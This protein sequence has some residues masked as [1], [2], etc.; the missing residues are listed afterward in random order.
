MFTL[1]S[2]EIV[3]V[4]T[5]EIPGYRIEHFLAWADV[6][7]SLRK[8]LS[9]EERNV[10]FDTEKVFERGGILWIGRLHGELAT[11][12]WTRGGSNVRSWFLPLAPTWFVIS[13]C[14]T[15][16]KFRGLGLFPAMLSFITR[17]LFS[18]GAERFFVDCSDWNLPSIQG[19][20]KVGFRK[21]GY[22]TH[23]RNGQ[24]IWHQVAKPDLTGT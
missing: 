5:V 18:Q 21:I 19:I 13:H 22:G 4:D 10:G 2:S 1:A 17:T 8:E 11:A 12:G 6:R 16:P 24:L 15:L 23:K 3:K 9:Y 20:E 14:V 7:P